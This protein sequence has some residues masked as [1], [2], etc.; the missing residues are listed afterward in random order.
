[1]VGDQRATAHLSQRRTVVQLLGVAPRGQLPHATVTVQKLS[2]GLVLHS[3]RQ[4][5][6]DV[7]AVATLT[8]T[9]YKTHHHVR[10]T[11]QGPPLRLS[12]PLAGPSHTHHDN[13]RNQRARDTAAAGIG[14]GGSVGRAPVPSL[15]RNGVWCGCRNR[16][17]RCPR[18]FTPVCGMWTSRR[19]RA[20]HDSTVVPVTALE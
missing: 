4:L 6:V 19:T 3:V 16:P 5:G 13:K 8:G 17:E 15:W 20:R 12:H 2:V 14:E 1:M 10:T 9:W 18:L 11:R 7:R